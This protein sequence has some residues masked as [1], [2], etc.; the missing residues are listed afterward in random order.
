MSPP[1][2][3]GDLLRRLRRRRALA[4]AVLL[5]ERVWPAIWPALG[6]AGLF[7]CL[8]LLDLPRWLPPWPHALLLAA[9]A[10]GFAWLLVRGLRGVRTPDAASADRR[11]ER[12]SSLSHRPLAA[13]TD[14]PAVP[15]S[16]ALWQAHVARATERLRRLRVG[17]PHPGLAARDRRALRGGLIVALAAALVIA[18]DDAGDR[19]ARAF[20]PGF[21][22]GPE[23]PAPLLQAWITP[24]GYT[25]IAPIFLKADGPLSVPAGSHLTISLTGGSGR[26]S[27]ALG[28]H[29]DPFRTLDVASYQADR[30]LTAS[31]Q[32]AVRRNGRDVA[33]WDITVI[34][35][36]PPTAAWTEP[37]GRA[38]HGLQLRL[39]WTAGDD[40]GVMSLQAELRLRDRPDVPPLIV[41][42]PL[43]GG[44]PK[45]AHGAA[46]AD[47]LA[48]PWAGLPVTV[49]LV[50]RDALGQ[51]GVSEDAA[52]N[53]PERRFENPIARALIVVRKMLVLRPD[54]RDGAVRELD[55]LSNLT[56]AFGADYGAFLNLRAIASLLFLDPSDGAVDQAQSRLWQLA[57]HLEENG[58]ERTARALE[59]ARQ[60]LRDALD[61]DAR[62]EHVDR[63]ELDRLM[64]QL[65]QALAQHLQALAQQ[66]QRDHAEVPYD[67]NAEQLDARDLSRLA[68]QMREAAQAGRM[69]EARRDMQQL[70]QMLQ[71]LQNARPERSQAQNAQRQRGRQQM[72]ALQDMVQRQGGLLDH[73]EQRGYDSPDGQRRLPWQRSQPN[74]DAAQPQSAEQRQT[75]QRVQ[76]ALR[77]ALGELMQQFGDLTGKIPPSL[78]EA[79]M[80]MHDAGQA[81][82]DNNDAAA[83]AAEQRALQALQKGGREMGQQM[84]RQF[85]LQP[86]SGEGQENGQAD[87]SDNG[88]PYGDDGLRNGTG[89]DGRPLPGGQGQRSRDAR[90]DPLGR[91]LQ[92]GTSGTDESNDVQVPDKMEQARTREIQDELRRRG[93]DRDRSKEELDYIDRLLKQF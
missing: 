23:A 39:P 53:L 93:A 73:A 84:A 20:A 16:E 51:Q 25:G 11:L 36:R 34:P 21:Q 50:A 74:D 67:P 54:N 40:Y 65:Q 62:G 86:G 68:Q 31:G 32:V 76:Q 56:D 52:L 26:P 2:G 28:G 79:D 35:D 10:A 90:R 78:G 5:F 77:R 83:G 43:A 87:A 41:G 71:A 88:N 8:A 47:L 30:D 49:R 59:A 85:G 6:L 4:R 18:G 80:A 92:Q 44:T 81:L 61:R 57:L 33:A 27:L 82:A 58:T 46:F 1:A 38:P 14:R 72:G 15:G 7:L 19:V 37:P 24:P 9:F 3:H 66:A 89:P 42:I 48:H 70:E 69:D 63:K 64:R 75:D 29:A 60:A 17:L 12:A 45:S 91:L 22:P 55:R 13:L